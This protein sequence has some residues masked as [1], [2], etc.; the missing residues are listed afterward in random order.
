MYISDVSRPFIHV[1]VINS[2]SPDCRCESLMSDPTDCACPNVALE[3]L[4][5]LSHEDAEINLIA[6]ANRVGLV[7]FGRSVLFALQGDK[8]DKGCFLA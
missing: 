4:L 6:E 7:G 1:K 8:D 2:T 3:A 5:E